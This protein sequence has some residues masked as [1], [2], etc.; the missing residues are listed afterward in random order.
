VTAAISPALAVLARDEVCASLGFLRAVWRRTHD[1]RALWDAFRGRSSVGRRRAWGLH[2]ERGVMVPLSRK[3]RVMNTD[4]LKGD[5]KQLKGKAK[6]KWGKLSDD[7]LKRVE[8]RREQ[9]EG[10]L[11][12]KYG[13]AKEQAKREVDEFDRANP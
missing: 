3:E 8:G 9:L 5:W 4:T 12:E 2:A 7:D 10:V 1:R 13:M 11:Q 6:A